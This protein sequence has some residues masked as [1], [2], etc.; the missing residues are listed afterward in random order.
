MVVR[1]IVGMRDPRA[2]A[3][4]I[5][6]ALADPD[7]DSVVIHKPGAH[8]RLPDGRELVFDSFGRLVAA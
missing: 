6:E 4:R 1:V 8:V 2:L 5:R 3:T 7:V